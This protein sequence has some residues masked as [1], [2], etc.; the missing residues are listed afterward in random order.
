MAVVG[1]VS[2]GRTTFDNHAET[3]SIPTPSLLL[4]SAAWTPCHQE[5]NRTSS[6][7]RTSLD[8][9]TWENTGIYDRDNHLRALD[10]R[11]IVQK[12]TP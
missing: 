9:R 7:D 5:P 2:S 4:G 3:R 12:G 11:R 8:G 6:V 10:A 1:D